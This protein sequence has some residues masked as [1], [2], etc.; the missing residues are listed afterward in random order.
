MRVRLAASP[1]AAV[2]A[3]LIARPI[4]A[5]EGAPRATNL[6]GARDRPGLFTQRLILPAGYCGPLHIH[7]GDV[8]GL[9]LRG[10]LRMGFPDS[11]DKL[12]VREHPPGSLVVVPA[13]RRHVEGSAVETEIHL[14]GVGPLVTTVIEAGKPQRCT[15]DSGG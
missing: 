13:G 2:V 7:N 8:H 12:V 6:A 1:V 10:A 5:Q 9:V 4:A 15:L 11:T 3:A 14:S